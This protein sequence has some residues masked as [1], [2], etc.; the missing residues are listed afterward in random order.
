MLEFEAIPNNTEDI[1]PWIPDKDFGTKLPLQ[2]Y[3]ALNN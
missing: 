1:S 3:S 2:N